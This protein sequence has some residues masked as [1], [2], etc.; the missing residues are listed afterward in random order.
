MIALA[1]V[2]ADLPDSVVRV[3][4]IDT[5]VDGTVA[6]SKAGGCNGGT[7]RCL[8]KDGVEVRV[9]AF[10]RVVSSLDE[11]E[12]VSLEPD[13]VCYLLLVSVSI[14]RFTY[15]DAVPD[16]WAIVVSIAE[17]GGSDT[18]AGERTSQVG[19]LLPAVP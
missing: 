19:A 12:V 15:G 5:H 17:G 13:P 3:D 10:V 11:F 14:F 1:V 8:V 18:S 9:P 6:G 4:K 16:A 2:P 7:W